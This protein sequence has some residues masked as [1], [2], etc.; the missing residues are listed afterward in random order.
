MAQPGLYK[1]LTVMLDLHTDWLSP[2]SV[3]ED[4]HGFVGY[5]AAGNSF[6]LTTKKG[7][8]IRAG[9]ENRVAIRAVD[10]QTDP[11]IANSIDPS[12]R[13]C[14]FDN[15]VALKVHRNYTQANCKLECAIAYAQNVTKIQCTPWYF[16]TSDVPVRMCNP[17]ESVTF[18][19]LMF[20]GE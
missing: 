12:K 19:K 11:Q 9:Y 2:S 18:E 5:V 20:K 17:W 13:N 6:P 3:D 7:F 4:F 10:I 1:G 8:S 16:P 14:L 15:E